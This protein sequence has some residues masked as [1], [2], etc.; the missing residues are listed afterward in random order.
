MYLNHAS[1]AK[2]QIWDFELGRL[3]DHEES[4]ASLEFSSGAKDDGFMIKNFGE[5]V[6]DSSL[7]NSKILGGIYQMTCPITAEHDFNAIVS[8]FNCH[9]FSMSDIDP[10][11]VLYFVNTEL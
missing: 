2:L 8:I 6:C 7:T 4:A 10:L 9:P 11:R 3:R 1:N 5:L